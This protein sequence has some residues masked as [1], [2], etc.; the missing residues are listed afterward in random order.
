MKAQRN[1]PRSILPVAVS[2]DAKTHFVLKMFSPAR[3]ATNHGIRKRKHQQAS[4]DLAASGTPSEVTQSPSP[5]V[6]ESRKEEAVTKG[7]KSQAWLVRT[8]IFH[9]PPATEG[10]HVCRVASVSRYPT[11]KIR[12]HKQERPPRTR[13]R[14]SAHMDRK[15][16]GMITQ[17][18]E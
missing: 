16:L 14:L 7:L 4:N 15:S 5:T 9:R 11:E 2:E 3:N 12:G 1:C 8:F 17:S 10:T 18:G 6:H 13:K